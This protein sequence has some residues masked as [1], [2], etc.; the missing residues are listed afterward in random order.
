MK[1]N[2]YAIQD[3]VTTSLGGYVFFNFFW[4]STF[5]ISKNAES[6]S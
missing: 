4:H 3:Y 2:Y 5:K 1:P 6:E